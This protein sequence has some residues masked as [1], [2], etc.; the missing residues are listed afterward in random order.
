MRIQE[1]LVLLGIFVCVSLVGFLF[2]SVAATLNSEG[3]ETV[4]TVVE[5]PNTGKCYEM[6]KQIQGGLSNASFSGM[7]E[8]DCSYLNQE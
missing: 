3:G 5:S 1:L 2:V 6:V 4:W 8:I 7:A